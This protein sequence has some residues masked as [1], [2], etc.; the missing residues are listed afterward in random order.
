VLPVPPA[1][2]FGHDPGPVLGE[3]QDL[4]DAVRREELDRVV[5]P[6]KPLDVLAQQIAAEVACGEWDE[7]E[8]Y[9]LMRRAWPY[10]ELTREEYGEVLQML[11]EGFSTRRGRKRAL[12]HRDAVNRKLRPRDGL[13][14]TAVTSG[15]TIPDTADYAVVLSPQDIIVG[16]VNEDFAVESLSGDVF[17][18]GNT[19]YRILRVEAGRVRV[20]DAQGLPPTI[21]F[22]LGEAPAR[23]DEE[24][25]QKLPLSNELH[26]RPSFE[27]RNQVFADLANAVISAIWI[28]RVWA[29]RRRASTSRSHISSE[30]R[31]YVESC[32][33]VSRARSHLARA[34]SSS[35]K[36]PRTAGFPSNVICWASKSGAVLVSLR[37][38]NRQRLAV[39][40]KQCCVPKA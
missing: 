37:R 12:I 40:F 27:P 33:A 25:I 13:R 32:V 34:S 31:K 15:G 8:L 28:P 39:A 2:A 21:P 36:L 22:W 24:G 35:W 4:L 23:S 18:L 16:T 26:K 17:Q 9:N 1:P 6:N 3:A 7:E 10:R 38:G 11:A 14:L 30:P 29:A 20:E 19:S 5:I